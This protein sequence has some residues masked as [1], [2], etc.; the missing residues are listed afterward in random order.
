MEFVGTC[1]MSG[2]VSFTASS[3]RFW[4]ETVGV[5]CQESP[6]SDTLMLVLLLSTLK[7]V[8]F[9]FPTL[10]EVQP[11]GVHSWTESPMDGRPA[12]HVVSNSITEYT[13]PVGGSSSTWANEGTSEWF[14]IEGH[15]KPGLS[16]FHSPGSS[17]LRRRRPADH[18]I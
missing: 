10:R 5:Y 13:V 6:Y 2:R 7:L 17:R 4:L 9:S 12:F 1:M 11:E 14:C 16:A 3:M 18:R 15:A 8:G